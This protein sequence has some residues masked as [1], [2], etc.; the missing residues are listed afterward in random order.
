M[1]TKLYVGNLSYDTTDQSLLAALSGIG[2]TAGKVTIVT[3]RATGRSR[4]FAFIETDSNE[5]ADAIIA[6]LNGRELDGRTLKVSVARERQ[7]DRG[8][9]GGGFGDR[10]GGGGGVGG[11]RDRNRGR[12]DRPPR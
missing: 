12:R 6:G 8:E 5:D 10:R 9:H 7:A 11:G 2:R 3:D 4:G 1:A